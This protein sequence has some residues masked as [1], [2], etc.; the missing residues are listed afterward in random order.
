MLAWSLAGRYNVLNAC[1][2]LALDFWADLPVRQHGLVL[3]AFCARYH[4]MLLNVI[5]RAQVWVYAVPGVMALLLMF[6][7]GAMW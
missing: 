5:T 6:S 7:Y 4:S 1:V 2:D 3:R